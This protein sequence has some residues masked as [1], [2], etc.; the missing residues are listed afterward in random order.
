M[1][2]DYCTNGD[3]DRL[4]ELYDSGDIAESE[5]VTG[6]I[7]SCFKGHFEIAKWVYSLIEE[8]FSHINEA[9]MASC[10]NGFLDI[11]KW[12]HSL[13]YDLYIE[14]DQVLDF[15]FLIGECETDEYISH[16]F[17]HKDQADELD[18]YYSNGFQDIS[19]WISSIFKDKHPR[20]NEALFASCINGH[21]EVANWLHSLA[22]PHKGQT[23]SARESGAD[24][25]FQDDCTIICTCM[26]G[27]LKTAKWLHSLGGLTQSETIDIQSQKNKAFIYSCMH[28]K[29]E[30]SKWLHS[31]ADVD[32]HAENDKAFVESCSAGYIVMAKWL[33]SFGDY[34]HTSKNRAFIR[35]CENNHYELVV[36]LHSLGVDVCFEDY[37]AF[38][39]SC[40][41]GHYDIANFIYKIDPSMISKTVRH[42]IFPIRYNLLGISDESALLFS[43]IKLNEPFPE[44]ESVEENVIRSLVH[45]NM[46]DHL[47][48]LSLQFP[49]IRFEV[50]DGKI[51]NLCIKRF[52][53]KNAYKII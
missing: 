37:G 21:I 47:T 9:F 6:F 4:K 39:T 50:I 49:F 13:G 24:I 48:E 16:I 40:R 32:I 8:K 44:I 53:S 15:R 34:S 20:I 14:D 31:L 23:D 52:S 17:I 12:L 1:F 3:I 38:I 5:K 18:F 36:W 11:A 45:Y 51:E 19:E 27:H 26:K 33:Y 43:C 46:I 30:T 7:S 22:L 2:V 10:I 42:S 41:R 35:C 28:G 25:R 29:L